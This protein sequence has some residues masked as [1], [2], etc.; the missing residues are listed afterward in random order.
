[1]SATTWLI[2]PLLLVVPMLKAGEQDA[3]RKPACNAK[4]R[5]RLWPEKTSRG[6]AVPIEICAPKHWT[7][8][9]QQLTVDVAQLRSAAAPK[10]VIASL[11]AATRTAGSPKAA[12]AVIPPD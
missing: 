2:I 8:R 3:E 12:G 4:S 5:G 11:V 9:W 1:M 6:A 10:P 7:Y